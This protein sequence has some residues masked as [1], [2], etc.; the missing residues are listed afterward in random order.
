[1]EEDTPDIVIVAQRIDPAE[2]AQLVLHTFGDMVKIVVDLERR[3]IAVGG[4]L[5]ADAEHLL[6][7]SGSR[8]ADLWGANYHP[9]SGPKECI[10]YTAM[11]NI[12]PNQKN[13]G[14]LIEDPD[15]RERVRELTFELIGQGEPLP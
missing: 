3:L 4:G 11:I 1:M 8:Q 7:E 6:L 9:G 13:R 12:R 14:M 5:H 2:L 15:V 10:E